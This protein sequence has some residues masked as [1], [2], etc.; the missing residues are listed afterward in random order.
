MSYSTLYHY[1]STGALHTLHTISCYNF[2]I[3]CAYWQSNVACAE[4][5]LWIDANQLNA[6]ALGVF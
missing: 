4:Y 6:T 2:D 3:S 5:P 1:F